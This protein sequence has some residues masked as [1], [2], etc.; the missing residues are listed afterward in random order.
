MSRNYYSQI[1]LH[2]V[3]H[4][5]D[6]SPLLVPGVE[7]FTHP[8]LKQRVVNTDGVYV[9]E[10]KKLHPE[11]AGASRRGRHSRSPGTDH[12]PGRLGSSPQGT[13]ARE[14]A[15]RSAESGSA[16]APSRPGVNAG[17]KT[18]SGGQGA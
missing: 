4:T 5:K 12:S 13:K 15:C 3:W 2:I 9:H 10:G 11:S 16:R 14:R 7:E 1:N 6:N 8:W 17:P 18:A